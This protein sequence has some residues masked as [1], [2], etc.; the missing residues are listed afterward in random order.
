M[1][2][3]ISSDIKPLLFIKGIYIEKGIYNK[4]GV[5]SKLKVINQDPLDLNNKVYKEAIKIL[6]NKIMRQTHTD[7]VLVLN[8][9]LDNKF[10]TKS[11]LSYL[12]RKKLK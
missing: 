7:N 9:K 3:D 2:L 10:L 12:A 5:D 4:L 6:T 8:F 1:I 11:R